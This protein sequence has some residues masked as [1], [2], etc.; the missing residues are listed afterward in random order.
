[1]QNFLLALIGSTGLANLIIFFVNRHDAKK[2]N[3]IDGLKAEVEK[4]MAE[5]RAATEELERSLLRLQ[6]LN[7]MDHRPDDVTQLMLIAEKY[8]CKLNGDWYMDGLFKQHCES[9][10]IPLP[11]WFESK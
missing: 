7:C 3:P 5:S 2:K 4:Y 8:F 1:M 9:H 10:S 11:S 6:M